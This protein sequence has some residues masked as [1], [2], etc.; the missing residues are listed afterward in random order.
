[1]LLGIS[2]SKFF[3]R[4][5]YRNNWRVMIGCGV[6]AAGGLA[7]QDLG[8]VSSSFPQGINITKSAFSKG[9]GKL[10]RR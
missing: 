9:G 10:R 1:M 6:L 2:L 8:L 5:L 7:G 4:S 3:P